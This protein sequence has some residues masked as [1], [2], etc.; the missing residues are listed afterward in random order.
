MLLLMTAL[1]AAQQVPVE[2]EQADIVVIGQRLS[3]WTGKYSIRGSK[4]RC[5]TKSSSGDGEI[6][7]LGCKAFDTCADQLSSRIAASDD[8]AISK[9]VR[10]TM[11]EGIKHDL[12]L[13]VADRRSILV[14][15][16]ADRRRAVRN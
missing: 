1:L 11:K 12:S 6:D 8:E 16:L 14:A 10:V 3:H 2:P 13:C 15:E 9:E 7:A 4:L 5:A